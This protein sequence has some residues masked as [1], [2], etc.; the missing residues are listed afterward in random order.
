M[1]HVDVTPEELK[2]VEY[3]L[4]LHERVYGVKPFQRT[5]VMSAVNIQIARLEAQLEE[6]A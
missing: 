4:E 3:M 1:S 5:A 6:D 2:R